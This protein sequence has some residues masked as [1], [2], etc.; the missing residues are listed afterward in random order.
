MKNLNNT[1]LCFFCR[2][3]KHFCKYMG[4]IIV[5]ILMSNLLELIVLDK[6]EHQARN[7][8]P[9]L[10]TLNYVTAVKIIM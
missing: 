1:V 10:E 8:R 9:H 3:S 7:V 4:K 6:P 2:F 5:N